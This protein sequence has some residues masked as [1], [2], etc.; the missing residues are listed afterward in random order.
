MI[1]SLA[2]ANGEIFIQT[3]RNLWW[4]SLPRPEGRNG[5][6][7][8]NQGLIFGVPFFWRIVFI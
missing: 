7:V 5:S 3:G 1:A 2:V 8:E 6:M 4:I